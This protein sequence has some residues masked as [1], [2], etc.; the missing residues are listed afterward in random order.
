MAFLDARRFRLEL[1]VAVE[2]VLQG[3]GVVGGG[4]RGD[5]GGGGGGGGGARSGR[6][7]Q[8]FV[9]RQQHLVAG[10]L[11]SFVLVGRETW[12]GVAAKVAAKVSQKYPF[13]LP[14]TP[15]DGSSVQSVSF[16][17]K[18]KGIVRF[19][20]PVSDEAASTRPLV[21]AGAA[22]LWTPAPPPEKVVRTAEAAAEVGTC[23]AGVAI[24]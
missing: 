2:G 11:S 18:A 9:G 14:P 1:G 19:L 5:A 16:D 7:L 17:S 23:W 22:M 8:H 12:N 6:F 3:R 10:R 24:C 21:D 4:G 13:W 15:L 20:S